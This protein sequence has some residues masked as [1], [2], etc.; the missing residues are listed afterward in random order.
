MWDAATGTE[1]TALL[2]HTL[3]VWSAA[4]SPDGSRIVT[5]SEDKTARVWDADTGAVLATLSGHS[6]A[7]IERGVQPRR[8]SRRHRILGPQRARVGRKQR[9]RWWPHSLGIRI[10]CGARRSVQTARVSS[11]H[12]RTRPRACGTPNRS[13]ARHFLRAYW[14]G[15]QGGIQPGW[16]SRR[17]GILRQHG[18]SLGRQERRPVHY[19]LRACGRGEQCG[20]QPGRFSRRHRIGG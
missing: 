20:I 7:G 6:G 13:D 9:A 4:F 5:A 15:I 3:L 18:A 16:L 2:G 1:L 19:I 8:F 10:G 12:P 14:P 11:L 17:H